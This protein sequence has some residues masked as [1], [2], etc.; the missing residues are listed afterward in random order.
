MTFINSRMFG[1]MV[2]VS[3]LLEP[4]EIS[5]FMNKPLSL[6]ARNRFNKVVE[7]KRFEGEFL[8]RNVCCIQ[9][10]NS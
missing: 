10:L 5:I 6:R 9:K 8:W 7:A 3:L 1:I 2:E 4:F